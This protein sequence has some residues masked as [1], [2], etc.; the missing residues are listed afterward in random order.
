MN[1]VRLVT[2]SAGD[3]KI[4]P[5]KLFASSEFWNT[6]MGS[7]GMWRYSAWLE[8]KILYCWFLTLRLT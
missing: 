1:F 8:K 5:A 3:Q 2:D 6:S 7:E 4:I